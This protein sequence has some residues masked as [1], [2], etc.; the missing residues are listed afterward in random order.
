[1]ITRVVYVSVR[2]IWLRW[3]S[4]MTAEGSYYKVDWFNQ[5]PVFLQ[6]ETGR[7]IRTIMYFA[8]GYWWI[9]S[10]SGG[11]EPGSYPGSLWIARGCIQLNFPMEPGP[12][13]CNFENIRW[14]FPATTGGRANGFVHVDSLM[15]VVELE[16][17]EL[18]GQLADL[19][20]RFKLQAEEL[21]ARDAKILS[22]EGSSQWTNYQPS[23]S[24]SASTDNWQPAGSAWDSWQPTRYP[25]K[26]VKSG[27][28][29]K[30]VALLYAVEIR[31][32]KRLN[33]LHKVFLGCM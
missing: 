31:D 22:L 24:A 10:C 1:M 15:A 8:S 23:G 20:A 18:A 3:T 16:K 4:I 33:F 7:P 27:W 14:C 25:E 28:L 13:A 26:E 17:A 12:E 9:T 19:E 2:A 6:A 11:V 21:K 30:C 32:T 29:N 5:M